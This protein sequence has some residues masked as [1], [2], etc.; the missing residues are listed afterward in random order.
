VEED[1]KEEEECDEE[2]KIWALA[3]ALRRF[4]MNLFPILAITGSVNGI[5]HV[6]E[7]NDEHHKEQR[8]HQQ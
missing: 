5:C 2:E 1:E 7:E 4:S 8:Y 3:V 6:S